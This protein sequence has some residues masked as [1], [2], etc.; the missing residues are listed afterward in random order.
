[1]DHARSQW[2]LE[3]KTGKNLYD[4]SMIDNIEKSDAYIQAIKKLLNEADI[5]IFSHPYLFNLKKFVSGETRFIYDAIDIEYLQKKGFIDDNELLGKIFSIEQSA[6][7]ESDIVWTTSSEDGNNIRDLYNISQNKIVV[8]PNGTD[9]SFIGYIDNSEKSLAKQSFG[10]SRYQTIL[11][12]GSWHPPNLEALSF[13]VEN[14]AKK[15][16]GIKFLII[17]SIKDYYLQQKGA[18]PDN[19]LAFGVV[20]EY[21]KYE[22]YKLADIAL[23]PMFSGSVQI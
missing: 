8:I 10:F 1:M 18:F 20:N 6:C 21:E 9:T 12:I 22:L 11:F 16:K 5:V 3:K 15:T 17:G 14:L 7:S 23:N 19:I 2:A 13:I 4:I